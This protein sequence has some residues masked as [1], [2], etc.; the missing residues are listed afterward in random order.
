MTKESLEIME[1]KFP[2][3]NHFWL[4]SGVLGFYRIAR[5]VVDMES[6]NIKA[7]ISSDGVSLAGTSSDLQSFMDTCYWSLLGKHYNRSN[8]N[9]RERNDGFFYDTKTDS[10]KRFD[11]VESTPIAKL[12]RPKY[13]QPIDQKNSI[14][15]DDKK[16]YKLPFEYADLQVKLDIFLK[17]IEDR[18]GKKLPPTGGTLLV[19]AGN[20]YQP[21]V[22]ISLKKH[23][24]SKGVCFLCGDSNSDLVESSGVFPFLTGPDGVFSFNPSAGKPQEVCWKC[25]YVSKFVPVN[26]FCLSNK[27]SLLLFFPYSS[28]LQKMNDVYGALHAAEY[29]DPYLMRNFEHPLGGYFQKPFEL[30]FAFLYTLYR[31]VFARKINND[32]SEKEEYELDFEKLYEITI[33]K[34]PLEFIVLHT[35]ALGKTQMGKMVWPFQDS[36]YFFRLLNRLEKE[37]VNIK[38]VMQKLVDYEQS[39]NEN[40]SLIRNRICERILRKQSTLDLIEQHLFHICK[41]KDAYI[42]PVFDF[43]LNYETILKEGGNGMEQVGVDAAVKLGKRIGASIANAQN[44]K[45][46]D[47]FALRKARKIEDFLNEV[48]RVQFK[49]NVSVPTEIYEGYLN[50]ETFAEFKQF[51]MIAAL[52]TFNGVKYH[53]EKEGQKS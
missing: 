4:D 19:N 12:L 42:A 36:V 33:S 23:T 10:F 5:D 34:A 48:N 25:N 47:L 15:Y 7:S 18:E 53:T 30:T 13:A 40:K 44:G 41:S 14:K 35:D 31:N 46:G 28:D 6:V 2:K 29:E 3:L 45:K 50:R 51:C 49:Y 16:T 26:G 24:R 11:K 38:E 39:K 22:K 32:D 20:A 8:K 52:N 27:G 21:S 37:G 43:V 17:E 1:L 9:Q